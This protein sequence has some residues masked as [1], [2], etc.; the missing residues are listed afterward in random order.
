MQNL[1]PRTFLKNNTF[2]NI[3]LSPYLAINKP[4]LTSVKL[5]TEYGADLYF[6][7]SPCF[8]GELDSHEKL[9]IYYSDLCRSF[10]TELQ[11]SRKDL[12]EYFPWI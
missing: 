4:H 6:I 2:K 9:F 1:C 5:T 8:Y 11:N 7:F 3:S 10:I 12:K